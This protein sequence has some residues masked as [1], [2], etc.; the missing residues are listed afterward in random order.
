MQ[1][2]SATRFSLD[3]KGEELFL[4]YLKNIF[5]TIITAG[6][7]F[8]WAKV[9]TQKFIHRHLV[10]QGQ[11]FDYHGTGKENFIGFLKGMGILILGLGIYFGLFFLAAK[12][13]LW[14][15]ILVAILF[16][17]AM[18]L[19]IPYITIGSRKYFL[20][21]T[22]F[23]NIR[24]RFTGKVLQLVRLF[25]PNALLTLVTL[26]FYTPWFINKTEKFF[27]DH[28]HLGNA[29]F[30]YDGIGKELFFI[31]LK[32]FFFTLITAGIYSF[33]FHANLHNYYWN[34][35]K[36]QGI[37]FRSELRPG[38]IFVNM[39]MSIVLVFF[40]LGIGIPWAYLRSIRMITN[41]LSLE[42]AP[43]LSAIQSVK[44]PSASALADGLQEAGEAISS[45]FGN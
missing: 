38:A 3:A 20:S 28:S 12:L 26:G 19:A 42:S 21:R 13:G 29:N 8:F 40:T 5:F 2:E 17:S 15:T 43:N 23:N 35:T 33:W 18:L 16:Y 31:Y 25:V 10:F 7:Y 41:S 27:I 44:D 39:L 37:P 1:S 32:G 4:I 24:F 22:S 36:F 6:V 11:R 14:A 34:H 9:N 45:V 30:Q